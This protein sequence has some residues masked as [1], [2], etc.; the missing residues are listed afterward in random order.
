MVLL[1]LSVALDTEDYSMLTDRLQQWVGNSGLVLEWFSS[2]LCD[3]SFSV[4]IA[5]CV[6]TR[7]SVLLCAPRFGP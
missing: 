1:D 3:R 7:N 5:I 4:A 6:F 2:Y